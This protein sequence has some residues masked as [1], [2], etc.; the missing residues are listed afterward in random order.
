MKKGETFNLIFR[1]SARDSIT[2]LVKP[3]SR[4]IY[5][6]VTLTTSDSYQTTPQDLIAKITEKATAFADEPVVIEVEVEDRHYY[7]TSA[8]AY[9]KLKG[10]RPMTDAEIKEMEEYSL[11]LY[12][13]QVATAQELRE[14]Q[15]RKLYTQLKERFERE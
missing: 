8:T 3:K 12:Q 7:D 2:R 1:L 9:L 15:D 11:P 6:E 13:R 4:M 5:D 14:E 10:W